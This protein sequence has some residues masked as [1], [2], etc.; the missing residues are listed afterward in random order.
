MYL[1]QTPSSRD[2]VAKLTKIYFLFEVVRGFLDRQRCKRLRQEAVMNFKKAAT[3]LQY[4]SVCGNK[5]FLKQD[6]LLQHDNKKKE[7][8]IVIPRLDFAR[9]RR[10]G[11]QR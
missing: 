10:G 7:G 9:R 2:E 5:L 11:L 3:F 4:S 6:E 8:I 1:Y